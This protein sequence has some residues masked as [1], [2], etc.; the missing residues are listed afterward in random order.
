MTP[1]RIAV[2]GAAGQIG[3]SLVY[4]IAAGD[5]FGERPVE[6][7]LLDL[8]GS[9]PALTGVAMELQDCASPVLTGVEVGDDPRRIFDGVNVAML[10]G[11]SPR[12]A[13]MERA[14]LLRANG[15]IF[16][17][18]G[19]ALAASAAPD[20]RVVVTG[21]L[22]NTNALIAQRNAD[23]VP[24]DRVTALT[25]LDHDRAVSLLA[26]QARRPAGDVTHMAIWGN[27]STTQYPDVY[28]ARICGRPAMDL[29]D[30][31][32][33]AF[34]FIPQVAR[35]GAAVIAA[36]GRS[37]AASA[38]NATIAHVRDWFAGT[39]AGGWT[40]MAVVSDGS[41]GV[42]EGLV[43]SFPVSTSDGRWSV[44][45][46]LRLNAL[47][48]TKIDASVRELMGEAEAVSRLGFLPRWD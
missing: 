22:A 43:S 38:A 29:V 7:R 23:G 33:V 46:D 36:R 27:H 18:Q 11:A 31:G 42:P 40:S 20:L 34:D 16:A 28:H 12:K 15:A 6:L 4:R 30:D 3:Y 8:P 25:R 41:Y 17:E 19:R 39:P 35:R 21:N 10:V 9:M 2:T 32:W 44:V 14:D 24:P 45:P 47:S 37:S 48:R 1:I 5:V 26:R 13:G